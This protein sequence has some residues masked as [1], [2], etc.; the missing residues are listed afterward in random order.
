MAL[1]SY[2]ELRSSIRDWAER[3]DLSDALI[4]DFVKMCESVFNNGESDG[5]G[6][7]L[8]R[9]LRT[10]DMETTATVTMTSGAG[11]LPTDFLEAIKV[12]DPGDLTRDI[13]YATPDWLDENFPTGQDGSFPAYYTIIGSTLYCPIDVSLTY[14]AAVPTITG[15]D[16]AYNWLLTK[17][18]TAYLYGGLMQYGIYSKNPAAAAGYRSLM[19]NALGGLNYADLNSRAGAM[20][21]RAGMTAY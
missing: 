17:A 3:S 12:K 18:P 6:G 16:G 4:L 5:M 19:I 7:Y 13:K 9:P 21:R 8:V 2:T 11:S 10:R 1:T 15:N 14:Y 20:V